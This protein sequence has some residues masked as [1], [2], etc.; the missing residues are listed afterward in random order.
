MASGRQKFNPATGTW[1]EDKDEVEQVQAAPAGPD[2]DGDPASSQNRRPAPRR[3]PAEH[4]IDPVTMSGLPRLALIL[5]GAGGLAIVILLVFLVVHPKA[6]P[7][8]QDLGQGISNTAGLKG[9]LTARWVSGRAQYQ[10]TFQPQ[11]AIYKAG[12]S[13]VTGH[14]PEPLWI[15]IRM[16]D[17]TGYALCSKQILFRFNP[18]QATSPRRHR[19][20]NTSASPELAAL[21]AQEQQREKG[22][23]VFQN[24]M[25]DDGQVA[26]VVAQGDLPC[27]EKEYKR[28][29][30]WDFTTNFPSTDEQKQI[31][32]EPALA[33][34]RA[35]AEAQAARRRREAAMPRFFVEGDANLASYNSSRAVVEASSG[36]AFQVLRSTDRAAADEWAADRAQVHY[37][38]DQHATC[39]LSR[40]GDPHVIEVRSIH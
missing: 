26:S 34:A 27:T 10:L 35:A 14:P 39:T 20:E 38:C 32:R 5:L 18:A 23:D 25:G 33:A 22:H 24:Q 7:S 2:E 21:Q 13:Y 12:F 28:F 8:F 4:G 17:A 9:E 15:N 19:T 31:M 1:V 16:L 37:N 6:V 36:Q 11:F 30:Y 3:V 40:S 29:G